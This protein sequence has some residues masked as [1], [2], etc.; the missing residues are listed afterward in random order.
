MAL[1]ADSADRSMPMPIA[2][3]VGIQQASRPGELPDYDRVLLRRELD[4]FPTGIST[5]TS[6]HH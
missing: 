4:L 3:L 2:T 1:D 5:S 6:E